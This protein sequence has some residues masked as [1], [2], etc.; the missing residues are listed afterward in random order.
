MGNGGLEGV[1]V[2]CFDGKG[3]V[4][5]GLIG[6]GILVVCIFGVFIVGMDVIW[7]FDGI[8]VVFWDIM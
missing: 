6:F 1:V 3:G 8:G 7:W 2:V 5:G 4:C